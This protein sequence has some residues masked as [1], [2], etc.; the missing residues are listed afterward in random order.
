MQWRSRLFGGIA[1]TI[2]L[3]EV[4]GIWGATVILAQMPQSNWY[5]IVTPMALLYL[6]GLASIPIAVIGVINDGRRAF[7]VV[8]LVLG[9]LNIFV[10]GV[11]FI[12]Y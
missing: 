12:S 3:I 7:A 8:A 11:R 6:A 4:F 2:C 1:L 10:C 5:R 9:I